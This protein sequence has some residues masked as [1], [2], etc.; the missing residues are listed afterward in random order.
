MKIF[1]IKKNEFLE[2]ITKEEL[3]KYSDNRFYASEQKHIEHLCGL[4]LIKNAAQT[5]YNLKDTDIIYVGK[6]P[7]FKSNDLK[8]SLSHSNNIILAA[9]DKSDI[10]VD[11]EFMSPRNFQ[12]IMKRYNIV[13]TNPTKEDFYKFWTEHEAKIKLGQQEAST[14]TTT[15]EKDYM[16]TLVCAD[17]IIINPEIIKL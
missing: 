9:F 1:Y 7:H 3:L 2:K 13:Y 8:F 16:L 14:Y 15:L 6:K 11:V 12:T 5:Y 4:Y 17:R 10:G